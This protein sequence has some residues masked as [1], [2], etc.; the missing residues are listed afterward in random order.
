VLVSKPEDSGR[1]VS[2]T[3]NAAE[4]VRELLSLEADPS[5]GALRLAVRSGCCSGYQYALGFDRARSDDHAIACEGVTIVVDPQSAPL[6]RGSRIDFVLDLRHS[7]FKV[8][9][10]NASS[11]CRCGESFELAEEQT[12]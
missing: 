5:Q 3:A 9:N 2:V 10:P 6:V 8:E 11:T 7:G 4:K 12:G 1:L